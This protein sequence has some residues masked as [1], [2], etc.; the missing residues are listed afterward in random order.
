T[1]EL[2]LL[3]EAYG[4]S[5]DPHQ[6][7]ARLER[8]D[9]GGEIATRPGAPVELPLR[10]TNAGDT[11]WL[12]APAGRRG[13]VSLGGHLHGEDG[14]LRTADFFRSPLPRDVAPGE[15]VEATCA[16][17]SAPTAGRYELRIDLVAEGLFWFVNHGSAVLPITL[18]VSDETPDSANPGVLAARIELLER[19][20]LVASRGG[21]CALPVRVSNSGNTL[22]LSG[23]SRSRGEVGLGGRLRDASG[24]VVA[25][26]LFRAS[27]PRSVAP[28]D[29]VELH[30]E[31]TAPAVAGTY[32]VELDMVDEGIVWFG[33]KGSPTTEVELR[34]S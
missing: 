24:R 18:R 19:G 6:L 15:T 20:P 34:V 13:T 5:R 33:Q 7:C 2:E 25:A 22:W 32:R 29:S 28:G 23:N 16:F 17:A 10:I 11:L 4:D 21:P 27:L 14:G 1:P 30:A 31:I 12:C 3:V 8:R 9:G 26:D